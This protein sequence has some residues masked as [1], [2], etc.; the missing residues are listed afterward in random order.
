M[1][2]GLRHAQA[3]VDRSERL[4]RQEEELDRRLAQAPP[5]RLDGVME[6]PPPPRTMASLFGRRPAAE[7][8]AIAQEVVPET[9]AGLPPL[10]DSDS[11][12]GSDFGTTLPVRPGNQAP[13][14][15]RRGTRLARR[16]G[17]RPASAGQPLSRTEVLTDRIRRLQRLEALSE[18]GDLSSVE[19][20]EEIR[21]QASVAARYFENLLAEWRRQ[22]AEDYGDEVADDAGEAFVE[23]ENVPDEPVSS[24][25]TIMVGF[26]GG[27]DWSVV[28]RL[29]DA[30]SCT[31][32]LQVTSRDAAQTHVVLRLGRQP[33]LAAENSDEEELAE[34][35]EGPRAP[36][37]V[38]AYREPRGYAVPMYRPVQYMGEEYIVP[39]PPVAPPSPQP[40]TPIA[41]SDLVE[42]A[43][44]SVSANTELACHL[45]DLLDLCDNDFIK[46]KCIHY[47]PISRNAMRDPVVA[48]DGHSYERCFFE[49]F[50]AAQRRSR[51]EEGTLAGQ[52]RSPSTGAPLDTT[53]V[54]PNHNL[55]KDIYNFAL[56]AARKICALSVTSAKA[57]SAPDK[58]FFEDAAAF[59]ASRVHTLTREHHT[60]M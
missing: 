51:A 55:K 20:R 59:V 32:E 60:I 52:Y 27:I 11:D 44:N 42:Q 36:L 34:A 46:P 37:E 1:R 21:T 12:S 57:T 16:S 26:D 24:S 45:L 54:Y 43:K 31:G 14:R 19:L 33:V 28:N 5:E 22:A 40:S 8:Q 9:V 18:Y 58:L 3:A 25:I 48:A 7:A 50:C 23:L 41:Y 13:P 10:Q 35:S 2:W 29:I 30:A 6:P 49:E 56:D 47:C 38:A 15:L 39:P 17:G 53:V 4:R